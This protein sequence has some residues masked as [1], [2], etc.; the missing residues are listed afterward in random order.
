MIAYGILRLSGIGSPI[1][2]FIGIISGFL[3][4]MWGALDNRI[5]IEKKQSKLRAALMVGAGIMLSVAS[6]YEII[7]M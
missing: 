7:S 1:A 4:V 2:P 3:L 6:V 5:C